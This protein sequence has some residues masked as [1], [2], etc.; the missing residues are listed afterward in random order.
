LGS[1]LNLKGKRFGR[2]TVIKQANVRIH[3]KIVWLC[4][5]ECGNTKA[6]L[7]TRLKKGYTKSCGCIQ[8][9]V[10]KSLM[11]KHGHTIGHKTNTYRAWSSMHQR[12]NNPN[13]ISYKY[14]GGRGIT[15]CERWNS[16]EDFLED[17]G[18][19]PKG[20]TLDRK[21]ND[22]NYGPANCSW[23]TRAKQTQ[24]SRRTKLSKLDVAAI[25][26]LLKDG[27][28]NT[29]ISDLFHITRSHIYL[30]A[31]GRIWANI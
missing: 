20:L 17:M 22:K 18:E 4:E 25:R 11:T 30:I 21:D 12:C 23:A 29:F 7:G 16:F 9:E 28:S 5:C 19:V 13:D 2:L 3:K 27:Y 15:I 6:V 31:T 1:A 14:Y 10:V 24:N 26:K 8:K